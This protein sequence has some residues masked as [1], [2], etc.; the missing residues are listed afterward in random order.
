[1]HI[2]S[3]LPDCGWRFISAEIFLQAAILLSHQ[4]GRGLRKFVGLDQHSIH[5][6]TLLSNEYILALVTQKSY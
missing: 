4:S 1:M 3:N 6:A 5:Y 2:T